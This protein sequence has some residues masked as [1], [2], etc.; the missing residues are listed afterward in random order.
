MKA[1][2]PKNIKKGL[3][4]GLTF[5]IGPFT[6]S[7]IQLFILAIGIALALVTFTKFQ[8]SSKAVGTIFAIIIAGIFITIAFFNVSELNI[9]AFFAK[10]IQNRFFDTTEKFQTMNEKPSKS[11]LA[12]RKHKI[13]DKKQKIDYKTN[14][15]LDNVNE[16]DTSGLI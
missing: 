5:S 9:L 3:L 8:E 14:I 2:F 13:D 7:I 12:I 15:E 4:S 16:L 6:I 11:E 10:L 1:V